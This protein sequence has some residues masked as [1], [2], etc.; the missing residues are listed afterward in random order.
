MNVVFLSPSFPPNYYQF[1]TALKRAGANV[2]AVGDAPYDSLRPELKEALTEYY[3]EPNMVDYDALMRA[4]GYLT[5]RHGH[6][7][8]IDSNNEFWMGEEAEIRQDFNIFGQ[9]PADVAINRHKM[10]MKRVYQANNIPCAAGEMIESEEGLRAFIKKNGYPVILKPD[11]GVG[12]AATYKVN[13]EEEL[14]EIMP[15]IPDGYMVESCLFGNLVSFDGLT[16]RE[17][18]IMFYTSHNFNNGIMEVVT[19]HTSM[20]Y[21]SSREI[22]EAL[23]KV[24]FATVKAFGIKERFFH[25]EF[26]ENKGQYFGLEVNIRTP[27]G[28]TTDMM[29]WACDFNVYQIWADLLV[30]NVN[31]IEYERR[32]HVAHASRRYGFNYRYSHEEIIA[33]L[34]DMCITAMEVPVALSGAM[35]DFVYMIRHPE[36]P[37]LKEAIA[38]IEECWD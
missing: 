38:K 31:K 30:N 37:V 29:N 24:G 10:G 14:A 21:Y 4:I 17:G 34:G 25:L 33:M 9:K 1:C 8:R 3:Y 6:I 20:H 28:F 13:N 35:G 22:P 26:F 18:N 32:Y 36:L 12:A 5:Y 27:G 11:L 15:L 7:D 2:L 23:K 19:G 16:D